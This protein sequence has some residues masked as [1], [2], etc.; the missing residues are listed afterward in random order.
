MRPI[1]F[2]LVLNFLLVAYVHE[3]SMNKNGSGATISDAEALDATGK[4]PQLV[5]EVGAIRPVCAP[6]TAALNDRRW[7]PMRDKYRPQ[8]HLFPHGGSGEN[9]LCRG[10]LQGQSLYQIGHTLNCTSI[11]DDPSLGSQRAGPSI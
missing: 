4:E 1:H 8:C 10:L 11:N 7:L 3:Q 9:Q 6:P 2:T 5:L